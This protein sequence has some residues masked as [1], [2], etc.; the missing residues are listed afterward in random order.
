MLSIC[1]AS[2]TDELGMVEKEVCGMYE[3]DKLGQRT[4]GALVR[5]NN[6]LV[7]KPFPQFQALL[8]KAH[9]FGVHF[10]HVNR[11]TKLLEV[12]KMVA[13]QPTIKL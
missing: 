3:A 4:V 7:V 1:Y 13:N 8:K 2:V 10:S 12:I 11:Q 5:S 6:K 9:A